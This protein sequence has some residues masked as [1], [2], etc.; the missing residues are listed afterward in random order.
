MSL[1]TQLK[2]DRLSRERDR[3]SVTSSTEKIHEVLVVAD[4]NAAH[5]S[6]LAQAAPEVPM[7]VAMPAVRAGDAAHARAGPRTVD[8][9]DPQRSGLGEPGGCL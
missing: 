2:A 7:R 6:L 9:S 8:R 3:G 4:F 1:R 5:S